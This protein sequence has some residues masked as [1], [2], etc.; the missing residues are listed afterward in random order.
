MQYI[1]V[2]HNETELNKTYRRVHKHNIPEPT[3]M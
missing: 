3:S 1:K 2:L